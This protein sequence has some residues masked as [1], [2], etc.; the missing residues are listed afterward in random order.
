ML[1]ADCTETGAL[2]GYAR[3]DPDQLATLLA[4]RPAADAGRL[5]GNGYLAFTVDQGPDARAPPGHRRDRGRHAGRDGAALFPHQRAVALLRAPRLRT[6]RAD[7][8]RA[9]ALILEKIAGEGGID[10]TWTTTRPGG[11]LAHRHD[12]RRDARPTTNCSTTRCRRSACC[13]GCSTA[14]AWR[15]TGRA[16]WP[17]AAAARGR[18]CPASSRGFRTDD[19]DHMAVDGEIVMTCEFCNLDFR[20]P[21]QD[22]R[23]RDAP[24]T[25]SG[26]NSPPS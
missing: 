8:W 16:R 4:E 20:F 7:G 17:T 2:R 19:L 15:P 1:L 13:T 12:A 25:T 3:A 9:G 11:K 24:S 5:L 18:G 22:V 6:R 14:K 10:P 21:R 23:G 26:R